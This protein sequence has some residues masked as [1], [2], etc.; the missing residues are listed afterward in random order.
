MLPP[1]RNPVHHCPSWAISRFESVVFAFPDFMSGWQRYAVA[2]RCLRR[3]DD[4][5]VRNIDTRYPTAGREKRRGK[6]WPN[7]LKL[8]R[9]V[10]AGH[11]TC[12]P[13]SD[14]YMVTWSKV[15]G[16]DEL[17][18]GLMCVPLYTHWWTPQGVPVGS[19]SKCM[20]EWHSQ[21]CKSNNLARVHTDSWGE[22]DR[23]RGGG[24]R[25]T[26]ELEMQVR[27]LKWREGEAAAPFWRM[28]LDSNPL[29][30]PEAQL[31]TV[32]FRVCLVK[33]PVKSGENS[34]RKDDIRNDGGRDGHLCSKRLTNRD[35]DKDNSK[36]KLWNVLSCETLSN[37]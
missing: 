28:E 30:G 6:K 10:T 23:E 24:N 27:A 9:S 35:F 17:W 37:I 11:L 25:K 29:A 12:P 4:S 14:N 1:C 15:E 19:S 34:G 16:P 31:P 26:S 20:A 22:R 8:R 3:S 32:C 5:R 18:R 13:P 36:Q 21:T 7:D 2:Y 33:W